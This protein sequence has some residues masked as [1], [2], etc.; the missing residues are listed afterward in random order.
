MYYFRLD[1]GG[2]YLATTK[3]YIN[4]RP[5]KPNHAA[6][7]IHQVISFSRFFPPQVFLEP[8][9]LWAYI[10]FETLLLSL[11]LNRTTFNLYSTVYPVSLESV[12]DL[13]FI[14]EE[15]LGRGGGRLGT[16]RALSAILPYSS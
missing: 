8:M 15:Q 2:I 11:L 9:V 13:A 3:P 4:S 12:A 6:S 10:E 7:L 16:G 14:Q 5:V 1:S